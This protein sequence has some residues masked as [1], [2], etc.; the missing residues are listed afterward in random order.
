[1]AT[2]PEHVGLVPDPDFCIVLFDHGFPQKTKFYWT[3]NGLITAKQEEMWVLL[4]AEELEA[5]GLAPGDKKVFAAPICEEFMRLTPMQYFVGWARFG[6]IFIDVSKTT[7]EHNPAEG[8]KPASVA[9]AYNR[10]KEADAMS[11]PNCWAK[12]FCFLL[13][14][15]WMK[16]NAPK[17]D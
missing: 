4:T 7:F 6:F 13:L 1:M 9:I 12:G 14:K 2:K 11:A 17:K 3:T 16:F 10:I 5:N 8:N 15:G